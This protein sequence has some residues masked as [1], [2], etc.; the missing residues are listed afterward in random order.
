ADIALAA[1]AAWEGRAGSLGVL[2]VGARLEEPLCATGDPRRVRQV[3]DGL[4]ENALRATP[5][6]GRVLLT[7]ERTASGAALAVEDTG[8]GLSDEDL[9]D[10]FTRGLLRERY[11]E[12]REVGTGLGLSIATRLAA[13]MD[14]RVTAGHALTGSGARFTLVLPAV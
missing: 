8:P 7:T 11:R 10:A 5:A 1:I 9:A 4:V 13:R 2:L 3:L 14:G 6:A 12:V